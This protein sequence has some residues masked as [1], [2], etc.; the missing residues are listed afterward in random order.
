MFKQL[1][2]LKIYFY[3][4]IVLWILNKIFAYLVKWKE[5][6]LKN[7]QKKRWIVSSK[8][9]VSID[10]D[11]FKEECYKY[12]SFLGYENII[13]IQEGFQ[14]FLCYKEE[15]VY[16]RSIHKEEGNLVEKK[17]ILIFI[18]Y[19]F[20]INKKEGIILTNTSLGQSGKEVIEM[21]KEKGYYLSIYDGREIAKGIMDSKE[22][23]I[24]KEED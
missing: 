7:R 24:L 15:Q 23:E 6:D 8:W 5:K 21:L 9:L 3:V 11:Y 10:K 4:F 2:Y 16:V 14:H 20:S 13:F 19:L 1:Q 22:C 12:L 17:D 18:G